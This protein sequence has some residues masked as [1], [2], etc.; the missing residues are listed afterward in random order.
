MQGKPAARV[1]DPTACP[2]PGHGTSPIVSGSPDVFFD[3]LPV[4]R[5]GDPSACG[6]ALSGNLV[7]NVFINGLP[8]ATLGS[9]GS[10]G[11]VVIGGSGTVIIGTAH[12]AAPTSPI[13][14]PVARSGL[15]LP[16]L[17]A[18]AA[19]NDALVPLESLVAKP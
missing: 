6:G 2:V 17:L 9:I 13:S 18:A 4:A 8:V 19:R 14:S 15:C 10:H 11:N 5:Q 7:P 16:C 3:G 12:A 1:S